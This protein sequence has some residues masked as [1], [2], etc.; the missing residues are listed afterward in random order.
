MQT[1]ILRYEGAL[2]K[3]LCDDKGSTLIAV[4]GLPPLAHEDDPMRG[5][6]GSLD[7]VARLKSLNRVASIGITTGTAFCGVVGG[8]MRREYSV[9]GDVVNLSA[10]L[11]QFAGKEKG[12]GVFCDRFTYNACRSGIAF[13]TIGEIMVKGK[14]EPVRVYQPYPDTTATLRESY[15]VLKTN[16]YGNKQERTFALSEER[17]VL[18]TYEMEQMKKEI[19]IAVIDE[20]L[21]PSKFS[22]RVI[23]HFSSAQR[24]YKVE[25]ES[26]DERRRFCDQVMT[27]SAS[28][29]ELGLVHVPVVRGGKDSNEYAEIIRRQKHGS[30]SS[31]IARDK[32]FSRR[33]SRLTNKRI[34]DAMFDAVTM[35]GVAANWASSAGSGKGSRSSSSISSDGG[36]STRTSSL[37]AIS[38]SNSNLSVKY[39]QNI[40]NMQVKGYSDWQTMR[41]KRRS[42]VAGV[43]EFTR[44]DGTDANE[45]YS[46]LSHKMQK[47]FRAAMKISG[48]TPAPKSHRKKKHPYHAKAVVWEKDTGEHADLDVTCVDL[49]DTEE[50][51]GRILRRFRRENVL[52]S[53]STTAHDYVLRICPMGVSKASPSSS[54]PGK[55]SVSS[56]SGM[57]RQLRRNSKAS[58]ASQNGESAFTDLCR[59]FPLAEHFKVELD[60]I[61]LLVYGETSID[62]VE[63]TITHKNDMAQYEHDGGAPNGWKDFAHILSC[64]IR[65]K[66]NACFRWRYEEQVGGLSEITAET[67]HDTPIALFIEG[68]VGVGKSTLLSQVA[69]QAAPF[70]VVC[71]AGNQYEYESTSKFLAWKQVANDMLDR[72]I[73][74][75]F[76]QMDVNQWGPSMKQELVSEL[77]KSRRKDP[78]QLKEGIALVSEVL[79]LQ[80]QQ[81][82]PTINMSASSRVSTAASSDRSRRQC[83]ALLDL[84]E[85]CCSIF[86]FLVIL[87]DIMY[88]DKWSLLLLRRVVELQR[89]GSGD[90]A[91]STLHIVGALRSNHA[92]KAWHS[93]DYETT[94]AFECTQVV[95]LNCLPKAGVEQM[96]KKILGV[97][98]VHSDL[99]NVVDFKSCGNPLMAKDL[100]HQLNNKGMISY[101]EE[102]GKG[103]IA[104]FM[105]GS[106]IIPV[107]NSI[108]RVLAE[109]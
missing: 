95:T 107:P 64:F 17:S 75:I 46:L 12:G 8:N 76:Y 16:Q 4:Y 6:L 43:T 89:P 72:I 10:R 85:A 33:V 80:Q 81:N 41:L 63:Y 59:F 86:H 102:H 98:S 99:I 7:I 44:K 29:N 20:L 32:H 42:K 21:V 27:L 91:Y 92:C 45:L 103:V 36:Y 14:S 25:F 24:P 67:A 90:W 82:L 26:E 56:G 53:N 94:V 100:V 40:F 18:R 65:M 15:K 49:N 1:A 62:K 3:F 88:M 35:R 57:A 38:R 58:Q 30:E 19:P 51:K 79:E 93:T 31:E 28:E 84:L 5:I 66:Q 54:S 39:M 34:S 73:A 74:D 69:A 52:P 109:K 77:M 50:L 106:G 68:D 97:R 61:P 71:G 13:A 48:K 55:R 22:N 104:T 83:N 101:A 105:P 108:A 11:M 9:L 96:V 78:T 47:R 2:N 60:D 70:I 23:M 87:D 37:K